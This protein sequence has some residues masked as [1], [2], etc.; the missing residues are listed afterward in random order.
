MARINFPI[1]ARVVLE[2]QAIEL[3]QW[4]TD[5]DYQVQKKNKEAVEIMLWCMNWGRDNTYLTQENR[6]SYSSKL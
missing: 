4:C 5:R 2:N 3:K 6:V 1:A